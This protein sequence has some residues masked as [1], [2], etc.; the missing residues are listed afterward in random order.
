MGYQLLGHVICINFKRKCGDVR[1]LYVQGIQD[2]INE[3][4]ERINE[5]QETY[6]TSNG[7]WEDELI[8]P[9]LITARNGEVEFLSN[10]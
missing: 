2:E 8:S 1:K 7:I 4:T 9:E 6:E 5:I 3:L 10:Q